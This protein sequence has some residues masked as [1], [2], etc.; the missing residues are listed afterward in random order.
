MKKNITTKDLADIEKMFRANKWK[1]DSELFNRY[2][3]LISLLEYDEKELVIELSYNFINISLSS[4]LIELQEAISEMFLKESHY[5]NDIKELF[6]VPLLNLE[7]Y[8]SSKRQRFYTKSSHVLTYLFQSTELMYNFFLREKKINLIDNN[9]SIPKISGQINSSSDKLLIMVDDFIGSGTTALEALD[10]I[11]KKM[12]I[13]KK[14]IK[15][16]SIAIHSDGLS[17]IINYGVSVYYSKLINKGISNE[18]NKNEV[19]KKIKIMEKIGEKF[20]NFLNISQE[21]KLGYSS[22]EALLGMVRTPNNTFPVFHKEN[23]EKGY[24]SPFPRS[25]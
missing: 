4:Y 16:I 23:K 12:K 22:S 6:V 19:D 14:K 25:W 1:I 9:L 17:K 10:F 21:E 20:K 24:Y 15:I 11:H 7:D 3:S 2:C 18:D 5:L 8:Y 13:K